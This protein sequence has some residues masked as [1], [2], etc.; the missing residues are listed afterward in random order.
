VALM[1]RLF[2]AK[3]FVEAQGYDAA[4]LALYGSQNYGLAL[5][6]AD[7]RS[8]VDIKCA[9]LPDLHALTCEEP[10]KP[11][12]LDWQGGQIEIKDARRFAEV[13]AKLNPAYL[14]TLIT[15]YYLAPCAE[16]EQ[17]RAIAGELPGHS[18]TAFLE[19]CRGVAMVK[20]KNLCHPFPAALEKICR[21]GY[22]GKQA[23]HMY[24]L[25][26]V[27]RTFEKTN[28][29]ELAAPKE[30]Y[31]FLIALKK[32]EIPLEKALGFTEEWAQ[33]MQEICA[34]G[35]KRAK[36]AG[37]DTRQMK[38]LACR[39]IETHVMRKTLAELTVNEA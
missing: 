14:E 11:A 16:F 29:Y 38:A 23:H 24:R 36:G 10:V 17:I 30:E 32:N 37:E 2:A 25:L 6:T 31:D 15:P 13:A 3:D 35:K 19:S 8:D 27:M 22:D 28:R 34:R 1:D 7:Y 9:V 5:D 4:Y 18:G 20:K 12:V 21:Y 26:L 33:E 39:A